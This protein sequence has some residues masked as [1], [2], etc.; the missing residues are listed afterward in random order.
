[1]TDPRSR[2]PFAGADRLLR[3]GTLEQIRLGWR[4]LRDPRVP[5]IKN[6]LPAFAALYLLSPI[7]PI[8]D[9]LLGIG[10]VDDLGILIAMAIAS[11]RLL[12][13]LAPVGVVE[14]HLAEIRGRSNRDETAETYGA[15]IEGVYRVRR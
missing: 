12:P 5:W 13:R 15:T 7:D 1:M 3:P 8:P 9:F 6:A 14:E 2:S 4:L 11:V 10:Q